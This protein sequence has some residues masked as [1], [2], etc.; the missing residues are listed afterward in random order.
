LA[1]VEFAVEDVPPVPDISLVDNVVV[2]L[3]R[4]IPAT[5][6]APSRIVIYRRP[7]EA[8]ASDPDDLAGLVHDVVVEQI[9]ELFGLEPGTVDPG[10][11]DNGWD[12]N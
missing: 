5:G 7:I 4:V 3:A 9:A 11:G 2:P 6:A 8:R 10:Y 12:E 1:E